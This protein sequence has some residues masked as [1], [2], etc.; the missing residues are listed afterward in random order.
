MQADSPNLSNGSH[1]CHPVLL[2]AGS[3]ATYKFATTSREFLEANFEPAI[4]SA[5]P[6]TWTEKG[7]LVGRQ[8][9]DMVDSQRTNGTSFEAIAQQ[10]NQQAARPV[11]DIVHTRLQLAA[12]RQKA[13]IG[14][15]QLLQAAA[16]AHAAGSA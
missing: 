7:Q 1:P 3:A 14:P 5:L 8:L 10:Y 2:P 16:A 4:F 12:Q 13:A 6:F 11:A 15:L 9:S